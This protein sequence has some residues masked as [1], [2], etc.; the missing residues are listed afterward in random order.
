MRRRPSR[1]ARVYR[2]LLGTLPRDF[3][4][5][6]GPELERVFSVWMRGA[7]RRWGWAGP[8]LV[9]VRAVVDL[10]GAHIGARRR[11][12]RKT[13]GG[14]VMV[15]LWDEVRLATRMLIMAPGFSL[16][17]IVTLAL[18][19][20]AN[21]AIF[22]VVNGVLLR[23]LPYEDPEDLGLVWGRM[24]TTSVERAPL[25]G[26][27]LLDFREQAR[28]L[29]QLAGVFG[30]RSTITG[31]FEP[32]PIVLGFATFNFFDVIGV[33]TKLGRTFVPDDRF[34]LDPAT[35][36]NPDFVPPPTVAVISSALWE[37]HFGSNLSVLGQTVAIAGQ[38][39][40]IVGILPDD[41]RLYLPA[42]GALP[43][44]VDV[45]TPMGFPLDQ[46]TRDQ[47]FLTVLARLA[48]GS[49]WEQVNAELAILSVEMRAANSFHENVGMEFGAVS[50]QADV[51]SHVRPLLVVLL[52]AVTFVLLIACANVANLQLIRAQK[53]AREMAVR[54]ALGGGRLRIARQVLIESGLL[55]FFGGLLGTGLAV[56][57]VR[58]ALALRPASL[59]RG[60]TVGVDLWVLGFALGL[61]VLAA[62]LFGAVPALKASSPDLARGLGGRGQSGGD[63]K[64]HRLRDFLVV[65]EIALSL[66]LLIGGG[67]LLRTFATLQKVEPGFDARG[68]LVGSV[69]PNFFGTSV[70]GRTQF[71]REIGEELA[72]L[73]GV[74]SVSGITPLPLSGQGHLW[75]GPFALTDNEQEWSRNEGDY[76]VVLPGFFRTAGTRLVTGR[77]FTWSDNESD[78]EPVIVIDEKMA[79]RAWPGE[80][81][82]G[83]ELRVMRPS[84]EGTD[85]DRYFARVVG[86]VEHVRFDD[87]RED[88][89]ETV[90]FP[91]RDWGFAEMSYLLRADVPPEQLV[92]P[93]REAVS[94]VDPDIVPGN[95]R[96]F[97][98]Y[99]EDQLAPTEFA[100]LLVAIFAG[101][102]LVLASVGLYG[103][104]AYTVRQRTAELGVRLALGAEPAAILRLVLRHGLSL[105]VVGLIVGAATS[106]LATRALSG[107]LFGVGIFDPLTFAALTLLLAAVAFLACW[108]PARRATRTDPVE[109]LRSE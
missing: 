2:A 77:D 55:A 93:M 37:G 96:P 11:P 48:P 42:E 63:R 31:D 43:G 53:R 49:T 71:F 82:I 79:I 16:V 90:Y 17:V 3:R 100:L 56:V 34:D 45:W 44:V 65:A 102:A 6:N 18:G 95:V 36:N 52:G 84:R 106:L 85:W 40:E 29:D 87:I 78:A 57:G 88:S 15:Q 9:W 50:L 101:V 86:V 108:V 13:D 73:P 58:G 75:F 24:T 104:I 68:V 26:L 76:R 28:T 35:F 98:T 92:A 32:R 105:I 14:D 69:T 61:S 59:P 7:R 5:R 66:V 83:R 64:A 60:D 67:L 72:T 97:S 12:A 21:T 1:H 38:N 62:L 4:E 47:Q 74:T 41:F 8:I 23:P 94:R 10:G 89:R 33:S 20:G 54:A 25:S 81:P 107:L 39:M 80:D 22:S 19:I 46:G 91:V 30:T 27:D 99:V 109:V 51:V 103:V 70:D